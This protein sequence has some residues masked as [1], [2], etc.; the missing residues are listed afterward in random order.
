VKGKDVVLVDDIIDTAGTLKHASEI[1]MDMGAA[2]VRAMCTH[3]VLSGN[4]YKNIQE[5][6]LIEMILTDTI[7]LSS[8]SCDK[9][10]VLSTADLFADVIN[11]IANYQSIS[12]HF[13]FTTIL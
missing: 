9:I 11:R 8:N 1:I 3:G 13:E 6:A 10:K 4:A 5:S 12:E 2:S 7:P